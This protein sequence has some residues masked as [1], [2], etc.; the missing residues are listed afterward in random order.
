MTADPSTPTSPP[1]PF[2]A[3]LAD[4]VGIEPTYRDIAGRVH[5][6]GGGP[7]AALLAALGRPP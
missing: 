1:G 7:L 3:R 5:S 2:L 4:A 6:I